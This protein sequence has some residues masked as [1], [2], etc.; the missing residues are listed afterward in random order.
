MRTIKEVCC[1]STCICIAQSIS[2]KCSDM[3]R[4]DRKLY[5]SYLLFL[6]QLSV[7]LSLSC[8]LL[9]L[10]S[11]A[12]FPPLFLFSTLVFYF[13]ASLVHKSPQSFPLLPPFFHTSPLILSGFSQSIFFFAF[14]HFFS[15]AVC[16]PCLCFSLSLYK[17]F[18]FS[19]PPFIPLSSV[20]SF[21]PP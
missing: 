5:S 21:I 4:Q 7:T 11:A 18:S 6:G 17:F 16:F 10:Q 12:L 2:W 1:V 20:S 15:L 19:K 8:F 14:F 9:V 3:T 13:S